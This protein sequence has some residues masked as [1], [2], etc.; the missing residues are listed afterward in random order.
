MYSSRVLAVALLP[1]ARESASLRGMERSLT[2]AG[3]AAEEPGTCEDAACV[4]DGTIV[5]S[6]GRSDLAQIGDG[7]LGVLAGVAAT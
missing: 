6:R 4:I 2:R 7:L 1:G 5:S 3:D